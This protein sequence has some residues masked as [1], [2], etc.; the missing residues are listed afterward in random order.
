[1][2]NVNATGGVGGLYAKM[3]HFFN[4]KRKEFLAHY[5]QRSNV[6]TTVMMIKTK[7]GDAVRS[8]TEPAARNEVLA[9]VLCHNIRCLIQAFYEL[10]IEPTF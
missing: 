7:F 1:M 8:K 4:Y 5:H 2:F 6:E 9:K 10:A 3:F